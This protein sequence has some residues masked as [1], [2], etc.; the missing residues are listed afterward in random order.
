MCNTYR[1]QIQPINS[2]QKDKIVSILILLG[3]TLALGCSGSTEDRT[4]TDTVIS[5]KS[6]LRYF[7]AAGW[8][9]LSTSS[10]DGDSIVVLVDPYLTRAKYASPETWDPNDFRPNYSRD[11]TIFSDVDLIDSEIEKADYILIHHAHP[12]HIM[13]A[14]YIAKKTGAVVIGHET[15]I[16]VMRAYDVPD[17]QL[18]TVRGGEDYQF[19]KMSVRVIP[20]LHSPLGDK[21]YYQSGTVDKEVSR[22]L[23]ISQLVEG[24]SLMFLVRIGGEV[25]LTMGSMNF[26]ER[27]IEGLR[28][29][30]ALVGAAPSHLEIQN[31]TMRLMEG[32]GFP[33]VVIVTHAD[34]YRTPYGTPMAKVREDW[35]LPFV[36]EVSRAS[37]ATVVIVPEHLKVIDLSSIERF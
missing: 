19:N 26:I 3:I 11:D 1:K 27:E 33:P 32:L 25:I 2:R 15:A 16:N 4:K 24:G 35:A 7:G 14:P 22:P 20:S 29:T 12:D 28:P 6:T 8:E 18:I 10:P 30:I 9:I 13:D 5:Q 23:K 21:R 37:P 34:N 36:D 31:Y 17:S